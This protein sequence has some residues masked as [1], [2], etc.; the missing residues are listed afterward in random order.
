MPP[1]RDTAAVER[2]KEAPSQAPAA[3]SSGRGFAEA[4]LRWPLPETDP[5][6]LVGPRLVDMDGDGRQD[7][8]VVHDAGDAAIG[9]ARWRVHWNT[10]DGFAAGEAW[11]LPAIDGRGRLT[12]TVLDRCD[13][14]GALQAAVRDVTADG[15]VDLV[16]TRGCDEVADWRVYP[17]GE[18]GF[19]DEPAVWRAPRL[20]DPETT[21]GLASGTASCSGGGDVPYVFVGLTSDGRPDLLTY[22]SCE[23]AG[24]RV[25]EGSEAG[26]QAAPVAWRAPSEL[27]GGRAVS[28]PA[29]EGSERI[30][31]TCRWQQGASF[32]ADLT[33]SGRSDLWITDACDAEDVGT[34]RWLRFEN[35]GDGF[36]E[37]PTD[38]SLPIPPRP[39]AFDLDRGERGCIQ[40]GVER[41]RENLL[42]ETGWRYHLRDMTADG[43]PDLVLTERC[44]LAPDSWT[45]H[46]NTGGGFADA[47]ERWCLPE[48]ALSDGPIT[49]PGPAQRRCE[50][51]ARPAYEVLELTGDA[52]PDLVLRGSCEEPEVGLTHWRV[53]PGVCG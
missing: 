6:P 9:A 17:G 31:N 29:G 18:G 53:F 2:P 44:G 26:Y 24:W 48:A 10:G 40:A 39:D 35:G 41:A 19:G 12:A 33:G 23:A 7:L 15:W 13:A 34:R 20:G 1:V 51:G 43:R 45:V 5:D 37:S 46:P 50:G 16:V 25:W 36:A 38:W 21:P 3:C 14:G 28:H 49:E 30:Q 22:R 27:A 42:P 32:L 52:C 47:G 8:L 4:P 11:S